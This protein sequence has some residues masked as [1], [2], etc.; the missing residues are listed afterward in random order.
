MML[1]LK[2]DLLSSIF[3]EERAKSLL[4]EVTDTAKEREILH[5]SLLQRK[6]RLQ[7]SS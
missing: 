6:S 5:K 7:V 2:K 1:Q 3:G 4:A